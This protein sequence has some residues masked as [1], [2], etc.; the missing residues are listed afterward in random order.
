MIKHIAHVSIAVKN[1]GFSKELFSKLLGNDFPHTEK[2]ESQNAEVSFYP[3]G[4]SS[5]E[6]IQAIDSSGAGSAITEFIEKRGEGMHHI[7]LEVDDIEKEMQR[8]TRL[9]FQF[10]SKAPFPGGDGCLVAFIH[11]KSANGV[12]VELSQRIS[13]KQA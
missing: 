4:E 5:I 10:A 13:S 9:G 7:C 3:V 12:L 2:I 8:L 6:L 1:L 11:P